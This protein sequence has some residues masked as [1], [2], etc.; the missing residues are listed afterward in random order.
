MTKGESKSAI[1][2]RNNKESRERKKEYDAEFNKK[3]SQVRKRVELNKYNREH[4]TY[5]D[6]N[7][8]DAAHHNGKITGYKKQ[9]L[10]RGDTND[11][12][13]D[14]R[15]RGGKTKISNRKK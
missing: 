5:G 12:A 7:G 9:S 6:G 4:G 10:N 1:F 14:R 3:P 15:A 11:S 8:M 13:G 2:Y